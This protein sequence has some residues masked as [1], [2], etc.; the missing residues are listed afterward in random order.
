MESQSDDK[1]ST[2]DLLLLQRTSFLVRVWGL[3]TDR[4]PDLDRTI[5]Q[6][7]VHIPSYCDHPTGCGSSL[8]WKIQLQTFDVTQKF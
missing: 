1:E 6:L 7:Q 8:S 2:N 5:I 4:R 3:S